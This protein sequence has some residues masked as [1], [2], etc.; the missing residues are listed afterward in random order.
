MAGDTIQVRANLAEANFHS[1]TK[2][3]LQVEVLGHV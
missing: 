1:P 2:A 3:Q